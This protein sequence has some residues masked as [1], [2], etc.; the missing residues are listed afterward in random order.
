MRTRIII[1]SCITALAFGCSS[2]RDVQLLDPEI[3]LAQIFGGPD[4]FL[5]RGSIWIHY[6]VEI[7]NPSS[8]S[9]TLMR[10]EMRTTS[11][12]AYRIT[13]PSTVFNRVIPPGSV[14]PIEFSVRGYAEGGEGARTIPVTVRVT[15][16]FQSETGPFQKVFHQVLGQ[17]PQDLL[18]RKE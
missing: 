6:L 9:I 3:R 10:I 11:P 16:Q 18:K 5:Y 12:G 17:Y 7:Q 4:Q 2:S 14:E 13:N 15:A 8:E 1:L